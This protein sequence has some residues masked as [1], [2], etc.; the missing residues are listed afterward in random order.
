[1]FA[2]VVVASLGLEETYEKSQINVW[3]LILTPTLKDPALLTL[4]KSPVGLEDNPDSPESL[5]QQRGVIEE[6][7]EG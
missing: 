7:L 2:K 5:P 6:G 4:T 1:M 3:T